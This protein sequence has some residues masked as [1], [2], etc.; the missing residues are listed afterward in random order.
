MTA[1]PSAWP[2]VTGRCPTRT[3]T[4]PRSA[5]SSASLTRTFRSDDGRVGGNLR[6]AVGRPAQRDREHD[7]GSLALARLDP[8][9][10]AVG[11]DDATHDGESEAGAAAVVGAALPEAIEYVGKLVGRDPASRIAHRETDRAIDLIGAQPDAATLR[12]E[13]Q[14]VG[15]Q[16]RE[17][18][19]E[20]VRVDKGDQ[21]LIRQLE[22]EAD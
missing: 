6:Q 14:R 4:R 9:A 11:F 10:A 21:P 16:I 19:V 5:R 15:D 17:D 2:R 8:D 3:R 22:V 1:R 20:L 18:A 7:G 13:L 12:R